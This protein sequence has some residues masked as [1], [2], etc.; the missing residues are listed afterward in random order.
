MNNKLTVIQSKIEST[1]KQNERTEALLIKVQSVLKVN[2][3]VK[4]SS[5]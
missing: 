5:S 4:P 1:I 2:N 3:T